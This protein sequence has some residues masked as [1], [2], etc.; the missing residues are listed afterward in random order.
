MKKIFKTIFNGKFWNIL[1]VSALVA[2]MVALV[3]FPERYVGTTFDGIKI[4]AVTVLPSLLPFFFLTALLTKTKA[5]GAF[6]KAA[7]GVSKILYNENGL[8]IYTQTMSFLSGYPVGAKIV[9]D[10]YKSGAIDSSRAEKLAFV[11]STSGPLFIVGGVGIGMFTDKKVG[12]ILLLSHFLSSVLVGIVLRGVNKGSID[13]TPI[14][15]S[16]K[17]ENALYESIYSSVISVAVVGGFIAVFYTLAKVL[18]D[19]RILSPVDFLLGK[20][21]GSELAEGVSIGLIECTTGI[22]AIAALGTTPLSAA[23]ACA[24]ITLGGL[25]VWCQS[26][27]YLSQAKVRVGLFVGAKILQA[28]IAFGLS[29]LFFI[30]F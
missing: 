29:Y 15:P 27:V 17:S 2:F 3:V 12:L 7:G 10:L 22:K 19:F 30:I 26:I 18:M 5:V 23:L 6:C 20:V 13:N 4:W 16:T 14:I 11:S 9:C 21:V 8:A 1:Y 25:S 24:L 28:A